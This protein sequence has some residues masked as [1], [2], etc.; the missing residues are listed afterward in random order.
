MILVPHQIFPMSHARLWVWG[1]K[2]F[3]GLKLEIFVSEKLNI[4][5]SD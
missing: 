1:D 5:F 4:E 3:L 2:D